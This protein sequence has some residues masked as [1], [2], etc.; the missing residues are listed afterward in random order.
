MKVAELLLGS[1][2][3]KEDAV[4]GKNTAAEVTVQA[5]NVEK[6]VTPPRDWT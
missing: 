2:V 5:F 6:L 1:S 3:P 4:P